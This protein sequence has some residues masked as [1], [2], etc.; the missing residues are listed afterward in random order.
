VL[1]LSVT[2]RVA[3][4]AP[5]A[6]G[7]NSTLTV[8]LAPVARLVPQVVADCRKSPAFVPVNVKLRPVSV[9]AR[10]FLTVTVFAALVVP[11]VWLA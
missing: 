11:T 8:Q 3:L 4:L 6:E 10:L 5:V 7:L 1:A 2:L 9:L